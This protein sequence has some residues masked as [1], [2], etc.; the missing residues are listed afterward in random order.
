MEEQNPRALFTGQSGRDASGHVS[1]ELVWEWQRVGFSLLE[2]YRNQRC[3][4]KRRGKSNWSKLPE[5]IHG[6]KALY[7]MFWELALFSEY[8]LGFIFKELVEEDT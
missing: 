3:P 2:W 6:K 7:V 4:G 1:T 5:E 8:I